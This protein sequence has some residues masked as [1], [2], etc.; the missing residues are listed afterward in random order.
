MNLKENYNLLWDIKPLLIF[1]SSKNQSGQFQ[2]NGLVS[3]RAALTNLISIKV[4]DADIE[5][6]TKNTRL[7][8]IGS[9]GL[10]VTQD[11]FSKLNHILNTIIVKIDIIIG[12]YDADLRMSDDI[13]NVKLPNVKTFDELTRASN[14]L[15]LALALPINNLIIDGAKLEIKSA[16]PGSIWLQVALGSILVLK[17][18]GLLIDKGLYLKSELQKQ[19]ANE[20]YL[21]QLGVENEQIKKVREVAIKHYDSIVTAQAKELIEGNFRPDNQEVLNTLEL[22]LKTIADLSSRG[23]KFLPASK[24]PNITSLFPEYKTEQISNGVINQL[25]DE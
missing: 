24:D 13:L 12:F 7:F 22:S 23:A 25:K 18:I 19:E 17:F 11:E 1:K 5:S 10:I 14:D 2:L 4:F 16:E 15:K 3:L 21:K 20:E 6:L 9:D 8:E